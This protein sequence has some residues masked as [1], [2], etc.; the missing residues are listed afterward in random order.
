[1]KKILAALIV[2]TFAGAI[3]FAEEAAKEAAPSERAP[4]IVHVG[5]TTCPVSGEKVDGVN[6]YEYNGKWYGMCCP[7]CADKFKKDPKKYSAIAEK[8][9]AKKK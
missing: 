8:E 2:L 4:S 9:A 5:N 1:M 7:A 6:F 3:S